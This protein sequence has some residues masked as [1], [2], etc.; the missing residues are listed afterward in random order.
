M[1]DMTKT[2]FL[3]ALEQITTKEMMGRMTITHVFRASLYILFRA[4]Y[5]FYAILTVATNVTTIV[6]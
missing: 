4:R 6:A 1:T 2:P 5:K 3:Y